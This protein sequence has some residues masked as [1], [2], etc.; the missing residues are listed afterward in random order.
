M[1]QQRRRAGAASS[2]CSTRSSGTESFESG[3]L[4]L[5]DVLLP[6]SLQPCPLRLLALL[7]GLDLR[8]PVLHDEAALRGGLLLLRHV[9]PV[10]LSHLRVVLVFPPDPGFHLLLDL[11]GPLLVLHIPLP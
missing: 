2:G 7:G 10:V 5:R 9:L 1:L 4:P 6:D 3:L 8:L 11:L